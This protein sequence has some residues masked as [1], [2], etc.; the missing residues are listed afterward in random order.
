MALM[1]KDSSRP[2]I[3]GFTLKR[4]T[5]E[6]DGLGWKYSNKDVHK[7]QSQQFMRPHVDRGQASSTSTQA[8][9]ILPR[10]EAVRD[11][12]GLRRADIDESLKAVD[13]P[14]PK[15]TKKQPR[16]WFLKKPV[17]IGVIILAIAV[18]G[19]GFL[20]SKLASITGRVFSSGNVFDLLGSGTKLKQDANGWTN[21]L[22]FGTSEDDKGHDG[23]MLTDSILVLSLNQAQKKATMVSMP[24]DMWVRYD[25]DCQFGYQGKINV[26]Y[27]CAGSINNSLENIDVVKGANA[28]KKKVGEV[29]GLDI[30]YYVKVNYAVVRESTTALGGVTVQVEGAFGAPGIYDAGMG[31]LLKL[32]NGP[33]TLQG[34]QALAFVRARGEAPGSYGLNGNFSREQNQQKMIVAIQKKALSSGTLTN[35]VALNNMLESLG[36]NIRTDFSTGEVKTLSVIGKDMSADKVVHINLNDEKHPVVN[37]GMYNGQSI[38]KPIAGLSDYTK[39]QGYIQGQMTGGSLETE[40]ATVVVLNGSGKAGVAASKQTEL[41]KAGLLNVTTGNTT[42]KPG[43]SIVW[44]D[45]TGGTKPKTQA[46]LANLLGRQ[47]TGATLPAGVQS[48][49]DFVI[50]IGDGT[51]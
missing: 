31:K 9:E 45:T 43:S 18:G 32:P 51:N 8:P 24:R 13:R 12:G 22:V 5:P 26:V 49:A 40:D 21:V 2:S 1:S 4:R 36:N 27:E 37:T 25:T 30:Q 6:N 7:T 44:Y 35:P 15:R 16:R 42:F 48:T 46:K 17:L 14:S 34:E 33:A 10:P 23:A 47:P 20:L 11:T 19:G 3:D 28:L 38:V 29:F 39:I 50:I 41:T